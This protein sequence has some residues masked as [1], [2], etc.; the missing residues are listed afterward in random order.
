MKL[1][2]VK[3][4]NRYKAQLFDMLDEWTSVGE[5]IVPYAIRKTDYH[6]FYQTIL[7]S[8]EIFS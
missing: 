7:T 8:D 4:E 1:K 3:L 6:D 2:L 5:K